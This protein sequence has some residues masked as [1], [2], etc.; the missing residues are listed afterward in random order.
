MKKFMAL[1]I[2]AAVAAM[3]LTAAAAEGS[4]YA[5][6]LSAYVYR[7]QVG[8]E[9]PVFQPGLDV[10]GP[11]GLG[12]SLWSSM[13]LTDADEEACPWYPDT[14]GEWSEINL[15]LSWSAPLEGPVGLSV[16]GTYYIFPQDPSEVD[17][18]GNASLA[19]ADGGYEVYVEVA[20]DTLLQP[21]IR[22]C[23]DLDNQDDW[24]AL[25][26]IGH[27]IELTEK[28][29]LDLGTTVG[30]AGKYYVA[31]NY[32]DSDAGDG[33]THVQADAGLNFALTEQASIGL[34]GAYSSIIDS[35]IRD[36]ARAEG[37]YPE[38]DIFFGGLTASYSF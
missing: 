24:C 15:G 32:N 12:F 22:F 9:E 3:P 11:L 30:Y 7:G 25:F 23:H 19:P 31:D 2:L 33:F 29:A 34:K 1:T 5:D 38:V 26:S 36:D 28:L 21:T 18:E 8:N 10:T 6:I 16:G 14:G 35:G 4:A 13:N 27:S 20:A 37:G 17:E